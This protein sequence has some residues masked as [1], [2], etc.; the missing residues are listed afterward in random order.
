[1][2]TELERGRDVLLFYERQ[3]WDFV[4]NYSRRTISGFEAWFQSLARAL[5]EAGFRVHE[6]CYA[7]AEANPS[8]PVG[9]VGT[10]QSIPK[11]PLPNPALLGPCMYDNPSLNPTLMDDPRFRRYIL[12][13]E[14][15]KAVF[16]KGY[17]G[18]CVLWH[19]GIPTDDWPDTSNCNKTTDVLVYD[20]IR[21]GRDKT[22]PLFLDPILADL[23]ARGLSHHV[24]R[25][26]EVTH[27]EYRALLRACR[28]MI[29]LC[30]HETQG[31]AYQE[32]LASNV[33]ILAWDHGWWTDPVWPAFS[34]TPIPACSV[35][36]F[37]PECGERFRMPAD[38]PRAFG[39]FWS[40]RNTYRPRRYIEEHVSLAGSAARYADFYFQI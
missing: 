35:P 20:K 29:F 24:L 16:E 5:R 33:P 21:W 27:E 7:L 19:A 31:L 4:E 14:W 32:A 36:Q 18:K 17:P 13:C 38:F 8:Y 26:G 22:V 39:E 9:L 37:S 10:P 15:L 11:W 40:K 2:S 3:K 23:S 12:T 25:Y 6:N 30:E 34:A 28:V 1:M